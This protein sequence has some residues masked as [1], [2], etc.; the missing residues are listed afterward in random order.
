MLFLSFVDT[1]MEQ[2]RDNE[3]NEKFNV[4]KKPYTYSHEPTPK[5]W[6]ELNEKRIKNVCVLLCY[7]AK[8][9]VVCRSQVAQLSVSMRFQQCLYAFLHV[10]IAT[11]FLFSFLFPLYVPRLIVLFPFIFSYR[12]IYFIYFFCFFGLVSMFLGCITIFFNTIYGLGACIHRTV[13]KFTVILW[14]LFGLELMVR[15][16]HTYSL[17][18]K[19]HLWN[20]EIHTA[21]GMNTHNI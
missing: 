1:W 6:K 14:F 17:R 16:A 11:A 2:K 8:C 20:I 7:D 13:S 4:N 19:N 18:M 3:K 15:K 5:S 9:A 10:F 21:N 12:Y